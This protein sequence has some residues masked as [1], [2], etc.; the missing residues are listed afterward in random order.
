M[1]WAASAERAGA[2]DLFVLERIDG[3]RL[4]N[5]GGH[6]RGEGWAGNVSADPENE[7]LLYQAIDSG[8]ARRVSGVPFRAFGPYWTSEIAAVEHEGSLVV[9][10]GEGVTSLADDDLRSV[11]SEALSPKRD[12]PQAKRDA[13]EL[14]VR[15]AVE[16]IASVSRGSVDEAA[17]AIAAHA[18][19]A[20]SCEFAALLLSGPPVRLFVADE[21]WRPPATEDEIIAA[22]LPLASAVAEGMLVEQDLSTSAFPYRPLGFEDGL[23]ARCV[24]PLGS[25]G[26]LGML[27]TAHAGTSPRG[28]TQLCQRVASEMGAEAE[29][30]L[31]PLS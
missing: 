16:S 4:F 7:P 15:Q 29:S 19:R 5:V 1:S 27:V 30:V 26:A 25:D 23:V 20:L 18:A 6:G 11:A 3:D 10:S 17:R 13:D 2:Q 9:V 22:L 14:E 31:T 28:F 21:G 12:V 8:L 24:V